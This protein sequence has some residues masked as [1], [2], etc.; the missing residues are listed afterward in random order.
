MHFTRNLTHWT[1]IP[2]VQLYLSNSVVYLS[3]QVEELS[4][5]KM[6]HAQA[7]HYENKN[8]EKDFASRQSRINFKQSEETN[9]RVYLA[10]F[11]RRLKCV[12]NFA[13][14]LIVIELQ[15]YETHDVGMLLSDLEKGIERVKHLASLRFQ[16]EKHGRDSTFDVVKVIFCTALFYTIFHFLPDC[17]M[18]LKCS[19]SPPPLL[20]FIP[21]TNPY[22]I[23]QA[24]AQG[25]DPTSLLLFPQRL[26][27]GF[28]Y[29][30]AFM[31]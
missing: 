7:R 10:T 14:S 3:I 23:T 2:V 24:P 25:P 27:L 12:R 19:L 11:D 1:Q 29:A 4:L 31:E 20:S 22:F 28:L 13:Q 5:I 18:L 30:L 21:S 17:W 16:G 26:M 6:L 9:F 8:Y 15:A